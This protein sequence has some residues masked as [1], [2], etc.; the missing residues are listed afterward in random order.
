M[1]T[2]NATPKAPIRPPTTAVS[3]AGGG[4]ETEPTLV[5]AS[6]TVTFIITPPFA[7]VDVGETETRGAVSVDAL[8]DGAVGSVNG[9]GGVVVVVG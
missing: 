5:V 9:G 3:N 2:N 6:A 8:S 4:G 1:T 7:K